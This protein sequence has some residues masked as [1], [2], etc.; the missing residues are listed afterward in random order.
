MREAGSPSVHERAPG[1]AQEDVLERAP[2]HKHALRLQSLVGDRH[3]R[4]AV[5]RVEQEAV[6]ERLRA[7]DSAAE[8]P[9]LDRRHVAVEAKLDDLSRREPLDQLERR[10]LLGDL[11]VI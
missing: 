8:E 1:Q 4:V 10:A 2:A 7:R 3:E 6:W 11:A 5:V 9:G